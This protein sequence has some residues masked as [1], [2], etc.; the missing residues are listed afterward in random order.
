[1]LPNDLQQVLA[2]TGAHGVTI[3]LLASL[4]G[5]TIRDRCDFSVSY[6]QLLFW[7]TFIRGFVGTGALTRILTRA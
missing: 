3:H 5:I 2:L 1:M 4:F 7:G 6:C